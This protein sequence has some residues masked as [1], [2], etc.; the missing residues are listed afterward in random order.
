LRSPPGPVHD[1]S[2]PFQQYLE[3]FGHLSDSGNDFSSVPFR[4]NPDLVLQMV[5]AYPAQQAGRQKAGWEDLPLSPLRR[6]FLQPLYRRA[7][8]F[9]LLREQ[10]SSLYT[11]GYGLFRDAFLELGRRFTGQ[12]WIDQP[13]DIFYLYL[14]EVR[15]LALSPQEALP[16]RSRVAERRQE[17][18]ASQ[19]LK[20]PEVIYGDQPPPLMATTQPEQGA[21]TTLRGI[22][23]SRGYYRGRVKVIRSVAEIARL[24]PG[25]VLVIPYSDVSWTPLF[26]RAGAVIAESGGV[27]SHSSIVAREYGLPCIVS[28][29]QACQL[30]DN[31]LVAI[32]GHQ[33]EI[34][35]IAEG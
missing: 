1:F 6:A 11:F 18:Q 17:M 27:L 5:L 8:L 33:G 22:P 28:V 7:R 20:L 34:R 4:E 24:N 32:D 25:D 9:V 19:A 31:T 10:I 15:Q 29:P 23:S 35:I 2:R 3:R 16:V 14:D 21:S 12:G 30:P 26:A 13:E